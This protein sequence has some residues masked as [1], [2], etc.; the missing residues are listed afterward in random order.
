MSGGAAGK[1]ACA[2]SRLDGDGDESGAGGTQAGEPGD[3]GAGVCGRN[4]AAVFWASLSD[5]DRHCDHHR[6]PA[7]S[8]GDAAG[9]TAAATARFELRGV[10]LYAADTVL[11]G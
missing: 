8:G 6:V 4:R 7:G 10:Q 11:D 9:E 1:S 2:T 3:Y 5:H